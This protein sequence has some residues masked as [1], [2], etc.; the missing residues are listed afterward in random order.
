MFESANGAIVTVHQGELD[1]VES[2][3][4]QDAGVVPASTLN[5][6]SLV[7]SGDLF[8]RAI[9][10]CDIMLAE[11]CCVLAIVR[12]DHV[13]DAIHCK[14]CQIRLCCNVIENNVGG[15][16]EDDLVDPFVEIELECNCL[17]ELGF[18]PT[19]DELR[20]AEIDDD[21]VL[22]G[23]DGPASIE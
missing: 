9:D 16:D 5:A 20:P 18:A 21:F 22:R 1:V 13:L 17:E 15:S 23:I 6:N 2:R 8:E 14:F 11:K 3:I 19:V 10:D 12:P 4:E 7:E